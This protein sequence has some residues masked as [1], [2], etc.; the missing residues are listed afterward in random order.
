[1]PKSYTPGLKVLK[2]TNISK[3]RRLPLKGNV[4]VKSNDIVN[5]N[6]IVASTEI[7][8]NVQMIN[9]ANQLNIDP[10]QIEKCMLAQINDS[11]EKNQL[12][13][14]SKGLFGMF[15]SDV[16]S[17][18]NGKIINISN[19]T[20]QVVVSEHPIPINVD[21]YIPGEVKDVY[22]EEG[23][24]INSIGTFVQGIIGIGGEKQGKMHVL[25]EN[26]LEKIKTSHITSS[27][28]NEIIVC[29]SCIDLEIYEK[30]KS[31]GVKGI[32][33]SIFTIWLGFKNHT[34]NF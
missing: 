20:G 32:I 17:P 3:E 21:A 1:M 6:T 10:N 30:A 31:V 16:K 28:E 12:I 2:D 18:I 11:V 4:H 7:P 15:K 5:S 26:P 29:G 34:R 14:Q 8:G 23:I 25:V 33:Y 19:V 22:S 13:A 24:L 9:V 27:L